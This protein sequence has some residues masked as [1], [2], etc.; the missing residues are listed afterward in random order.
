MSP[1]ANMLI[2]IKNAQARNREE[3]VVP[4]SKLKFAIAQTLKDK[5]FVSEVE[6]KKKKGKKGELNFIRIGLK[7]NNNAGAI[8]SI[9]MI[10]KPSR[11]I[12]AGKDE[13]KS[14]MSGFGISV[15]STSR[16]IMTG[17]D[18]RKAGLGGE[19]ICEIW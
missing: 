2:E 16:G 11:R 6:S 1:I 14:I 17:D 18:A 15:V 8:S 13:L 12:Y 5:G 19:V 7:Y 10:S 3:I 9:K 4:F